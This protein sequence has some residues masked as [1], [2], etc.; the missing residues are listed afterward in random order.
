MRRWRMRS[1]TMVD[2]TILAA[3]SSRKNAR[4]ERD[5]E[6]H[7]TK[8][9]NQWHLVRLR[10][11]LASLGTATVWRPAPPQGAAGGAKAHIG[12]D[13]ATGLVH[14]VKLTAAHVAD[15]TVA[16]ELIRPEDEVVHA[17]AGYPGL[18][19]R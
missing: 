9:G 11:S 14:R 8:K 12:V 6:M 3:P 18:A 7:Q 10:A 19:G 2:A 5:P 1:G 16:P 4:G 17:A 13:A 15:G